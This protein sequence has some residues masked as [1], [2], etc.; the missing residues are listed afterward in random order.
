MAAREK[1]AR[2]HLKNSEIEEARSVVSGMLESR[3]NHFETRLLSCEIRIQEKKYD[4]ALSTLDELEKEEPSEPRIKYFKGLAYLGMDNKPQAMSLLSEVLEINPE[5]IKSRVLLAE[6]HYGRGYFSLAEQE[7]S[8]VLEVDPENYQ[9]RLIKANAMLASGRVKEAEKE[10]GNLI[11][12]NP[13]KPAGYYRLAL[14]KSNDRQ[15][16]PSDELLRKAFRINPR[17]MDVFSLRIRNRIAEKDF[18]KAHELCSRQLDIEADNKHSRAI[19]HHIRGGI[20]LSRNKTAEAE[21][22]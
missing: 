22:E 15:Y 17:L 4:S 14:I 9:A 7:A 21:K 19:V 5:H 6:L 11:R 18:D 3:P 13:D 1:L 10:Y 2:F 20:Y 16:G 8:N 12:L